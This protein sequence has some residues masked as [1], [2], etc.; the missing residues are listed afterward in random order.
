MFYAR[1]IFFV[2]LPCR[3]KEVENT[4]KRN[5]NI[6]R[7][8]IRITAFLLLCFNVVS[9]NLF[10]QYSGLQSEDDGFKWIRVCQN[11]K[12]GAQSANGTWIIPLSRGYTWII[13]Q[14]SGG[15][16]FNV[17][18]NGFVQG[19]ACD[20]NG[21]EIIAP[22]YDNVVMHESDGFY[23]YTVELNGKKGV[24]DTDGQEI[25]APK[26]KS[27][28]LVKGV[29]KYENA[30][31]EWISTGIKVGQ[32]KDNYIASG[33]ESIGGK[34]GAG[35]EKASSKEL[36]GKDV[37]ETQKGIENTFDFYFP[38]SYDARQEKTFLP[39][40]ECAFYIIRIDI[41]SSQINVKIIESD[42]ATEKAKSG[43]RIGYSYCFTESRMELY[44]DHFN[45]LSKSKGKEEGIQ[46]SKNN[47]SII[48]IYDTQRGNDYTVFS[49]GH[50][51]ALLKQKKQICN[52]YQIEEN[53][54]KKYEAFCSA[55]KTHS[56]LKVVD[57][58]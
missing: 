21:K 30:S 33:T 48:I 53:F 3:K 49:Q 11:G 54:Q 22:N 40:S 37:K 44:D 25:I 19:G 29:F 55:L 1:F 52:E 57:Y 15:G 10:G 39:D 58:H 56:T 41:Q 6:S 32:N 31:G 28:I 38:V 4:G 46:I 7:S 18:V 35:N 23:Y 8:S 2:F 27:L 17:Y 42:G 20:K 12:E 24:Y 45:L 43:N 13:Y 36:F 16:W 47:E 9:V 34:G 14:K 51:T 26:Y 5:M 50:A